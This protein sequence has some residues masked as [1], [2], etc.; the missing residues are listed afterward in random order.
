MKI[1]CDVH[2]SFKIVKFLQS[3]NIHAIH[4]NDILDGDK[5]KDQEICNF[6]DQNSFVVLSKDAD[7]KNSHFIKESP[8][9]LLK[10]NLGNISTKSLIDILEYHLEV[11]KTE[12]T[13]PMCC[14]ELS[15]NRIEIFN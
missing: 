5:T 1:L 15:Q 6:A 12:F 8:R 14:I 9:Q 13:N 4:V 7:F 11:L 3:K 2:I 10:I